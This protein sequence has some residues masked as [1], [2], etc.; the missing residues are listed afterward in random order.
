MTTLF[1]SLRRASISTQIGLSIVALIFIMLSMILGTLLVQT[2]QQF[3][4]EALATQQKEVKLIAALLESQYRGL[5]ANANVQARVFVEMNKGTIDVQ[6]ENRIEVN[7]Q[8]TP[9][10][11]IS[12]RT[13]NNDLRVVDEFSTLTGSVATIFAR[14]GDDFVRV[15]TSLRNQAG[16]RVLGTY[17]GSSHP[18]YHTLL[19]GKPYIGSARLFGESYLTRY[20]PVRDSSGEVVAILFIGTSYTQL[21]E[22]I[23]HALKQMTFGTSGYAYVMSLE[24]KTLGE[25]V[26]HPTLKGKSLLNT[27]DAE[28]NAI[29]GPLATDKSGVLTFPWHDKDNTVRERNAVF[30]KVDGWNWTVSL[31]TFTSEYT[32]NIE[33]LMIQQV[34]FS[35]VILVVGVSIVVLSLKRQLQPLNQVNEQLEKIGHGDLSANIQLPED[36][37]SSQ[38]EVIRLRSNLVK[39]IA[40]LRELVTQLNASNDAVNT[41]AVQMQQN[42]QDTQH[43]AQCS[44]RDA[45]QVA[46]AIHQLS[47][48]VN[49]VA[50]SAGD[51]VNHAHQAQQV[52]GSAKTKV[53]HVAHSVMELSGEI[54][55]ATETIKTVAKDSNAIGQVVDVIR[56][57]AEQTNLLA[58]NAAIEAARAG[59]MGRGFAVVADEVRVLAQRTKDSTQE[60]HSVVA[61]LSQSSGL[62]VEQISGSLQRVSENVE[63]MEEA[64]AAFDDVSG[65]LTTVVDLMTSIASATEEQSVVVTQVSENAGDLSEGAEQT[66]TAATESLAQTTN[67]TDQSA[68][69]AKVVST[70]KF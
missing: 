70:F 44:Q 19:S 9:Q 3:W 24:T 57:V 53:S 13:V 30:H 2:K 6:P 61:E 23:L 32:D 43:F 52:I 58:L 38:N 45:A 37:E 21:S 56:E 42:S 63:E 51:T 1:S 47:A 22:D 65:G 15:S 10:L 39:T 20:D 31:G 66:F 48:T 54:R 41:V 18:G 49:E 5:V 62:A 29:F 55:T 68:S 27:T 25:L 60:I 12:G 16:E 59:E 34:L 7:G 40:N 64:T 28:G 69:M 50:A 26:L 36:A 4:D 35:I 46:T 8:S 67:L 17:L 11:Q 14:D 33:R